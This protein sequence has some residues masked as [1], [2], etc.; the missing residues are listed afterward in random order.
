MK[1]N[2]NNVVD[3]PVGNWAFTVLNGD[4]CIFNLIFFPNFTKNVIISKLIFLHFLARKFAEIQ[5]SD[6][7]FSIDRL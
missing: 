1:T 3:I 6:S 5:T 4:L 7:T 2:S